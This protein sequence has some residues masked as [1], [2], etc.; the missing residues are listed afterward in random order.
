MSANRVLH[1]D[2]SVYTLSGFIHLAYDEVS[3]C[4][5][6]GKRLIPAVLSWDQNTNDGKGAAPLVLIPEGELA[7]CSIKLRVLR[8]LGKWLATSIVSLPIRPSQI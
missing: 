1:I 7:P 4:K 6:Y 2:G 3:K 5:N 8:R